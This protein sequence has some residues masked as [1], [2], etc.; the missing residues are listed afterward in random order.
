MAVISTADAKV[1]LT[2]LF[3]QWRENPNVRLTVGE[4]CGVRNISSRTFK[5]TRASA[6]AHCGDE[7]TYPPGKSLR[8]G[9][10]DLLSPFCADISLYQKYKL[11]S[12][13]RAVQL[14][15]GIETRRV[16]RSRRLPLD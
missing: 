5:E 8:F 10:S 2:I 6:V 16:L 9:K 1:I 14:R 7:V 4:R 3:L 15:G 13:I 11:A 12:M